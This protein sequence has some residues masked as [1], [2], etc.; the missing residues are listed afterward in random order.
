[1]R[2][3]MIQQVGARVWGRRAMAWQWALPLTVV[4][5]V[6]ILALLNP[7]FATPSNLLNLTRQAAILTILAMGE[8]FPILGGGF[9]F[10]IGATVASA[11]MVSA[12][13]ASKVGLVPGF[14]AGIFMGGV[15]GTVNGFIVARFRVSP[16]VVTLA[17][18]SVLRG[19]GL[20]IT[21]GAP[22]RDVP[23]GYTA[24]G[25]GLL[26][27]VPVPILIA[28]VLLGGC[29]FLLRRTRPG[30]CIYLLGGNEAA[31]F[32]AGVNL[33][34]YKTLTYVLCGLLAGFAG[35]IHSSRLGW[36]E[37]NLGLGTDI[38]AIAA[39]IIGGV[40][41]TG[42]IGGVANVIIG[43]ALLSVLGNGLSVVG[44]PYYSQ[45]MLSGAVI[46]VALI[47]NQLAQGRRG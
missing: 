21:G 15:V 43:V 19:M 11:G 18:Y 17:M 8:L 35:V 24:L 26:G 33:L 3:E 36:G 14:L 27:P 13:T 40:A 2:G 10:S 45:L 38:D 23:A 41:L 5:L 42:G 20:M 44:V 30:R 1:M 29:Y 34:R 46:L 4:A 9:D 39:V 7:R 22:I 16:F 31:A 47:V 6:V 28:M 12:F 37:P 32:L 25:A